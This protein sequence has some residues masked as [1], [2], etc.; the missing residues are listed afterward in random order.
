MS[1]LQKFNNTL[2]DLDQEVRQLKEVSSV[3]KKI[4]R[5]T[6]ICNEIIKQFEENTNIL[7]NINE[8][9]SAQT[10][11]ISK[12]LIESVDL[13]KQNKVELAKIIEEKT[14]LIRKENKEFYRELEATIKIKL[15]ENLSQV[16]QLI[17]NERNQIK[18]IF[19]IEFAKNTNELKLIIEKATNKQTDLLLNNQQNIKIWLWSIGALCLI[20]GGLT[21]FK[22]W[23][24]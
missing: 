13:H 8:L 20:L 10:E 2:D 21:V 11:S 6:E 24:V 19:E 22:L 5:Q 4:Q 1:N 17:E 9:Q 12:N 16:K 23:M 3:Y 14:D 7:N 18:Q 15:D